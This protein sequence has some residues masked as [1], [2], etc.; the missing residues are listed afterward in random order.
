MVFVL[1]IIVTAI[2]LAA[3]PFPLSAQNLGNHGNIHVDRGWKYHSGDSLHWANPAFDDG[4]WEYADPQLGINSMPEAGWNGVGWFRIHIRVD[5]SLWHQPLIVALAQAGTSQVYVDGR[6]MNASVDDVATQSRETSSR[7][8]NFATFSTDSTSDHVLAIRYVNHSTQTFHRAGFPAGFSC[9]VGIADVVVE[10]SSV[11]HAID[12]IPQLV[13]TTL[14]VAFAL[15][16]L[17]LFL[18]SREAKGN[19]YFALFLLLF[20]GNIFFDYQSF[21]A[22]SIGG[23]LTALRIQRAMMALNPIFILLFIYSLNASKIPRQFWFIGA[24]LVAAGVLAV[25]KPVDNLSYPQ[26]VSIVAALE[27]L[28]MLRQAI[29][30][31]KDGAWIIAV[32]FVLLFLFSMYDV[33]LDLHLMEPMYGILNGYPFGFVGLMLSMSMYL[34]RDFAMTNKKLIEQEIQQRVLEAENS[35]K[36]KELEDARDLQLSMLPRVVPTLPHLDIAVYMKTATEVGGDYYDFHVGN[37]GTL[38]VAVGDATGHGARAGAMVTITKSLFHQLANTPDLRKI[39]EECTRTI[40]LLNLNQLYMAMTL[41]RIRGHR[42]I[43]SAAGMPPIAIYRA[44]TRTVDQLVLKGMPLGGFSR[45]P[46]Q[47]EERY[48]S[49]G[50]TL[51]LMS[52]GLPERFN[53]EGETLEYSRLSTVLEQSGDMSPQEIIHRLVETGDTWGNGKPQDDDVTLV[54]MKVTR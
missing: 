54:V 46:Y 45:F 39:F 49:P 51:V 15:L 23:G 53:N 26:I 24:A 31:G 18:F 14:A 7:F 25:F 33:L 6:L 47:E 28:R 43:A 21:L 27:V 5:S 35:R 36:S 50:D 12:R 13:F 22:E 32:G 9:Y 38:T 8:R 4:H 29:R 42:M 37:D 40:K 20:A 52:D 48:L 11:R 16:H 10:R 34:A 17:I 1:Q 3:E 44:D 19:L 41:V 30:R 2:S